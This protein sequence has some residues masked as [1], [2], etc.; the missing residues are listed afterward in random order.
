MTLQLSGAI[1]IDDITGELG[2]SAGSN[3]SLG[4]AESRALAG[5]AS[6]AISLSDFYGASDSV[7][8][9]INDDWL[10]GDSQGGRLTEVT[11]GIPPT[12]SP[13][14]RF[15]NAI[16]GG[17]PRI[18]IEFASRPKFS[19]STITTLHYTIR[20]TYQGSDPYEF[21]PAEMI[22]YI[23]DTL[24]GQ[25]SPPFYI[26]PPFRAGGA[27]VGS[28]VYEQTYDFDVTSLGG[29]GI[30]SIATFQPENRWDYDIVSVTAS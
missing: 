3:E 16:Q 26:D 5:V 10:V 8:F 18:N 21:F 11:S 30:L 17:T 20:S 25:I 29:P 9:N 23:R 12:N 1:S 7:S 2:N 6:G 4:S 27:D 28:G 24:G 15:Q 14:F 13:G 19:L 22:I